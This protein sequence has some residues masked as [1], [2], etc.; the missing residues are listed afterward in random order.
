MTLGR[1]VAIAGVVAYALLW[2]LALNGVTSLI[3]PLVI[4][5]VLIFLIWAGVAL[6]RYIGV[7]P[8]RPKFPEDSDEDH[9]S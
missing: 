6:E 2:V 4:P 9:E 7:T 1:V 3:A 5:A 8:H